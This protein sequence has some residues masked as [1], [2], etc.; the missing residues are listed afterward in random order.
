MCDNTVHRRAARAVAYYTSRG[1]PAADAR[2]IVQRHLAGPPKRGEDVPVIL[3]ERQ[4]PVLD[5][6][7]VAYHLLRVQ[8]L[9]NTL[10]P[11]EETDIDAAVRLI[12]DRVMAL[13]A[14]TAAETAV[15]L[16][17]LIDGLVP[18]TG[19]SVVDRVTELVRA[20]TR[21][22]LFP[23]VYGRW[24][25]VDGVD[26]AQRVEDV[27]L[28]KTQRRNLAVSAR[29]VFRDVQKRLGGGITAADFLRAYEGTDQ[30]TASSLTQLFERDMP[31]HFHA[32]RSS[33]G[34]V[35]VTRAA[36][37]RRQRAYGADNLD[38]IERAFENDFEDG[39]VSDY[40]NNPMV[41]PSH[42]VPDRLLEMYDVTSES[43]L[44]AARKHAPSTTHL[45]LYTAVLDNAAH[46]DARPLSLQQ[47][48]KRR[49][50]VAYL[51]EFTLAHH[52]Y[53][54]AY[55]SKK[56]ASTKLQ[57]PPQLASQM[58]DVLVP[59]INPVDMSVKFAMA[60]A[61]LFAGLST[62]KAEHV[63]HII[64]DT[65]TEL[66][67]M[68]GLAVRDTH[69]H[70]HQV[71][72]LTLEPLTI[73]TTADPV[74]DAMW[75]CVMSRAT[76]YVGDL[77]LSASVAK[78]M[79]ALERCMGDVLVDLTK[80]STPLYY[81]PR[82]AHVAGT[83][84]LTGSGDALDPAMAALRT[85]RALVVHRLGNITDIDVLSDMTGC[86]GGIIIKG[87][88]H[89]ERLP[90]WHELRSI[91]AFHVSNNPMLRNVGAFPRME[92]IDGNVTIADNAHLTEVDLFPG[93]DLRVGG[94]I[95]LRHLPLVKVTNF[96]WKSLRAWGLSVTHC[97][98]LTDLDVA[99]PLDLTE[100]NVASCPA[101]VYVDSNSNGAFA[102]R[103][104]AMTN[105]PKLSNIPLFW[106]LRD[107]DRIS[108]RGLG[109]T[110]TLP[111]NKASHVAHLEIADMPRLLMMDTLPQ[112]IGWLYLR[113]L[114]D[115][116]P[117]AIDA[118]KAKNITFVNVR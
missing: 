51:S 28:E 21:N 2:A 17:R 6:D 81:P 20:D 59:I 1:M 82:L 94:T 22:R 80:Q 19:N 64:A 98:A 117:F 34:A 116:L 15:H 87:A 100:M 102:C 74:T 75:K 49:L 52:A 50:S 88:K 4:T 65:E 97:L 95:E 118:I 61:E 16:S 110:K 83:F 13:D 40:W 14:D 39:F 47:L 24:Y 41:L 44:Q 96:T 58:A 56:L 70:M 57:Y 37:T 36:Y 68:V 43:I 55:I 89:L 46:R 9:R 11:Y 73:D 112:S 67:S 90:T 31:R 76:S 32:L 54:T 60:E 115:L 105:S 84:I 63:R 5:A 29:V 42:A 7:L 3:A 23:A 106:D 85:V 62:V 10:K 71:M 86:T 35:I 69:R 103:T 53:A 108:L 45:A 27:I 66:P 25:N 48:V 101:L 8:A 38:D 111:L 12:F 93:C 92:S 77:T 79:V 104:L 78:Y 91:S 109:L 30:P 107:A 72:P 26:P 33:L 99:L 114:P 113:N 18:Y